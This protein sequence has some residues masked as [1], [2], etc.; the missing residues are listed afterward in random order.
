MHVLCAEYRAESR[1]KFDD[2]SRKAEPSVERRAEKPCRG[3]KIPR[4]RSL[5]R[6]LLTEAFKSI[7]MEVERELLYLGMQIERKNKG[8]DISMDYYLEQLF[9]DNP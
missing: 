4:P 1:V 5:L 9:N 6:V 2:P 3:L 8:F 7:T